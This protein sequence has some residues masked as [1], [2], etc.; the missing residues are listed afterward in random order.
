MHERSI[1]KNLI[2]IVLNKINKHG[3]QKIKKIRI[4]V[5]EFTMVHDELLLSAF[6]QLSKLTPA[7]EAVVQI[8][9]TPLQGKCQECRKKFILN[10]KELKCPDCNS[11]AIEIISG[12]ELFIQDIEVTD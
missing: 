10:R 6:Y 12:D 4:V 5:G 9:H 7:K 3:K 1:A 11:Q 8:I 2:N